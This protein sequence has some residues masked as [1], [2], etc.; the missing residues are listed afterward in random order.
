MV[1]EPDKSRT[2]QEYQIVIERRHEPS[3]EKQ[4]CLDTGQLNV[5]TKE[6]YED[7]VEFF[8]S[9][10]YAVRVMRE[11]RTEVVADKFLCDECEPPEETKE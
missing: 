1:Y 4:R 3:E 2:H 8:R 6:D 11:S 7:L 9:R 10:G 5:H